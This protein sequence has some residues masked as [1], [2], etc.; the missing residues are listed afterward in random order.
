MSIQLG[1][2]ALPRREAFVAVGVEHDGHDWLMAID[3]GDGHTEH[4]QA[5]N[6]VGCAVERIHYPTEAGVL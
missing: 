4:R 5:M 3:E 1:A 6:Q 2:A